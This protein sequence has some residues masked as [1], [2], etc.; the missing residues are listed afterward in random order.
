MLLRITD[1]H[2]GMS[3][4]QQVVK[5]GFEPLDSHPKFFPYSIE[6]MASDLKW[7]I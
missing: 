2:A 3:H 4:S 1:T 6:N 5:P 7:T